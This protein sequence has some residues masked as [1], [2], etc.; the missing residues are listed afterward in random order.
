MNI[1]GLGVVYAG[2]AGVSALHAAL[3]AGKPPEAQLLE[4]EGIPV[5]AVPSAALAGNPVLAPARRADR[6]C[7]M[8]LLS[9]MEAWQGCTAGAGR[10]G[11]ILATA[12]GPHATVFRF[13]NEML[14]F[15]NAKV[16]PTIF[17]QSVHAAA[18]SMIATATGL[19]GPV[20]SLA[21]LALPFEEALTLAEGW[22]DRGRC[23]SVLVGAADELS[24]VLAHVVRRKRAMAADGVAGA[25]FAGGMA[26]VPGEGAVFFR[27]EREGPLRVS[28]GGDVVREASCLLLNTGALGGDDTALAALVPPGVPSF[29]LAPFWGS[30][31]IGSAFHLAAAVLMRRD[32]RFFPGVP[33]LATCGSAPAVAPPFGNGPI[34]LASACGSRCRVTTL[35]A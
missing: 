17:S 34:Q 28:L 29:S 32:G 4:K 31:R 26:A 12:F 3:T 15:G 22:L 27:L 13:V 9:A 33:P 20:L 6:F 16:S 5:L 18:A 2:G 8:T 24:D 19:H 10:T 1:A 7:K 30:T 21:D 23:D 25:A 35:H 14:D 11:I